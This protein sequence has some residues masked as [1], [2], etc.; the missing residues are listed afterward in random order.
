MNTNESGCGGGCT[1]GGQQAAMT[2]DGQ[3]A[4]SMDDAMAALAACSPAAGVAAPAPTIN[5]VAL[6]VDGAI[7]DSEDLHELACAELLRQRAVGLAY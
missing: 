7:Y 4:V 1:C 6:H 5:G 3:A 2:D